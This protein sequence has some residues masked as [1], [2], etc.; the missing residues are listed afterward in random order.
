MS[1]QHK[2]RVPRIP[3]DQVIARMTKA[4]DDAGYADV[5]VS[6]RTVVGSLIEGQLRK[7]PSDAAAKHVLGSQSQL[8]RDFTFV[9]GTGSVQ[10]TRSE[11]Q[12]SDEVVFHLQPQA[13]EAADKQLTLV[14]ATKEHLK[15]LKS[16]DSLGLL[17]PQLQHHYETREAELARLE[18]AI[19]RGATEFAEQVAATHAKLEDEFSKRR[20]QL[21]TTARE[22]RERDKQASD[23]RSK[24][25]DARE[26]ELKKR[27]ADIDDRD[28]RHVRRQIR[29]DIKQALAKR[30][31]KFELTAGT[32]LL[33]R[34]LQRFCVVLLAM[35]GL[36]I[37]FYSVIAAVDLFDT[38]SHRAD[39][40]SFGWLVL[41]RIALFGVAFASTAIFYIRWNNRW[42]EQHASEEFQLKRL[43]LDLDRASWVVEMAMEWKSEKGTEIPPHLLDR[44]TANLFAATSVEPQP[45]H[46]ADQLASA[47][48]GSASE[49]TIKIPGGSE[50]KLDRKGLRNL[51]NKDG[52][53]E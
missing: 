45:L 33:R 26:E 20:A 37:L 36:A 13:G 14:G 27:I 25:I 5:K 21:E 15:E 29:A 52:K 24:A 44:L 40:W 16:E 6:I 8:V 35:L 43:E 46:P 9:H 2:F 50:V 3:D 32:K 22:Q 12:F 11:G 39:S 42:F 38:A 18:S 10:I 49:A 31:E 41:A 34:P 53:A 28:S 47:L 1:T 23:E 30:A 19:A 4:F 17:G 51:G 7:L 48:L